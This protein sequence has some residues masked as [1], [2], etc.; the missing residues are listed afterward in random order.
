LESNVKE[1]IDA[2]KPDAI[3][4]CAAERRP[5]VAEK[6]H[7]GTEFVCVLCRSVLLMLMA[8]MLMLLDPKPSST[9]RFLKTLLPSARPMASF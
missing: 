5:D 1:F 3:I 8:N 6:D 7:V 2:H 9:Y 4:H